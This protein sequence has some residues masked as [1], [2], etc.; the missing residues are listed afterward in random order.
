MVAE[1]PEVVRLVTYQVPTRPGWNQT[2]LRAEDGRL[3]FRGT[4]EEIDAWLSGNGYRW[5]YRPDFQPRYVRG[6]R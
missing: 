6:K 4:Y 5:D 2:V 3:V 1:L